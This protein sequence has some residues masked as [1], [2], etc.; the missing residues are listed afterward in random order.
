MSTALERRLQRAFRRLPQPTREA[1]RRARAAALATLPAEERRRGLGVVF[2]AAAI[3][4]VIVAG[5]GALAATGNLHVRLGRD[6]P[7]TPR[8]PA[9]LQIPRG[10]DGIA[11]VADGRLWLATRGGLRI[12]DLPVSAAELSPRALYAAVGV[13]SSLV[14]LAPGN[15]RA[16]SH[17]AGGRVVEAAWSPDGLKI[18]Y[19]VRRGS[20]DELRLIEGDGDQ[21]RLLSARV[22]AAKPSWRADSLAVAYVRPDGRA[23]VY[24]LGSERR[25]RFD[26]RSCTGRA[27]RVAYAPRARRLAVLG[28][29]GVALVR[30]WESPVVCLSAAVSRRLLV[31][32]ASGGLAALGGPSAR[33]D[34][35]A[36]AAAPSGNRFVFAVSGGRRVVDIL[37]G[38]SARRRGATPLLRLHTPGRTVELSWR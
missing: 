6:Q 21:D 13:G 9:H 31:W 20:G 36:I 19:V 30:R 2:A 15:R 12:E 10:T 11:I 18:A 3:A 4:V 37:I 35:G 32:S 38:S 28:A 27:V 22:R 26:T 34:L 17:D 25:R 8:F 5:A 1:T 14:V 16:W 29:D 23:G 33:P 24:D 7:T